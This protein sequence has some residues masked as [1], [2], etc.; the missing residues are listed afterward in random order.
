MKRRAS[1][2]TGHGSNWIQVLNCV[3]PVSRGWSQEYLF[4]LKRRWRFDLAAVAERIA[5]EIEGGAYTGGRHVRG[6]GFV[7][8][9]EKYNSAT[10]Q[11]WRVLRY[12]PKQMAAGA[13]VA[14]VEQ[15]LSDS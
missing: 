11:G 15:L 3:V 12:T 14:D 6:K 8:D 7:A 5:I 2:S 9:M 10:V 1:V 4:D 13:F